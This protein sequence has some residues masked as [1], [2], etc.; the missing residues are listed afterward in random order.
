MSVN[1]TNTSEDERQAKGGKTW[2][3]SDKKR[4]QEQ[5]LGQ[6]TEEWHCLLSYFKRW[7]TAGTDSTALKTGKWV[8]HSS[9]PVQPC[10][11]RRCH[12]WPAENKKYKAKVLLVH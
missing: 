9:S 5:T 8:P 7:D 10:S 1:I 3:E 6:F 12:P 2:K 4:G 11:I